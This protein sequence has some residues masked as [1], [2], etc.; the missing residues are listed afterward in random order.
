MSGLLDVA[1]GLSVSAAWGVVSWYA[2]FLIGPDNGMLFERYGLWLE[3]IAGR[4]EARGQSVWL[5]KPLGLCGWCFT[6]WLAIFGA[7]W[8]HGK[9]GLDPGI[10]FILFVG[11][12]RYVGLKV[13]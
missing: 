10:C 2:Y 9:T 5:L 4:L 6:T 1:A 8:W 7:I 3:K 12:A 13:E 11:S